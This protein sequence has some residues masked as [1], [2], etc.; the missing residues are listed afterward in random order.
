M[1]AMNMGTWPFVFRVISRGE[2]I[3]ETQREVLN[4]HLLSGGR[5]KAAMQGR[6]EGAACVN[7]APPGDPHAD[8]NPDSC[9]RL[10]VQLSLPTATYLSR[11]GA[12]SCRHWQY[13]DSP[14]STAMA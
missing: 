1:A 13:A 2:G 5:S 3:P 4:A 10:P 11:R 9:P 12:E 6:I 7:F 8:W 14:R